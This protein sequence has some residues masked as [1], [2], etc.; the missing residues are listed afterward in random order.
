MKFPSLF[1][2]NVSICTDHCGCSHISGFYTCKVGTG[3]DCTLEF[4]AH[5]LH[6]YGVYDCTTW[7]FVDV[8]VFYKLPVE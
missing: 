6:I 5:C 3:V 7:L 2:D 1:L 4:G 8:I